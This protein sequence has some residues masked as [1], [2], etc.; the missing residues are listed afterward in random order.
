MKSS[1]A[2]GLPRIALL[3]LCACYGVTAGRANEP[4]PEPVTLE[5]ALELAFARSPELAAFQAQVEEAEG[6]LMQAGVYL[7]NPELSL[8]AGNR[9][10][11]IEPSE[12]DSSI[13]LTQ[14]I[15]VG[16]QRKR[17][18]VAAR[19]A[20]EETR[21]RFVRAR[22][23]LVTRVRIAFVEAL[24][25]RELLE[26]ENT[27]LELSRSLLDFTEKRLEAGKGT[28]IEVNLARVDF[29]QARRQA[30]LAGAGYQ[31][32]RSL[33][34]QT[35]GIDPT[36]PPE[37]RGE[38]LIPAALPSSLAELLVGARHRRADLLAA[39]QSI[40]TARARVDLAKRE[41]RPNLTFGAFYEKEEGTDTIIG[42]SLS[43]RLPVFNRNQGI[44]R[45][46]QASLSR[47]SQ[48]A[49]GT[50]LLIDREVTAT[51]ARLEAARDAAEALDEL[52]FGTLQDNLQLLQTA[53]EAGK[54]GWTEVLVFRRTFIE[55]QRDFVE[56]T[57][58][59]WEARITL[60]LAT[61]EVIQ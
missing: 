47:A 50:E 28:Q 44:I 3:L 27:N 34:A 48:E 1:R 61:G 55:G 37:P 56:T 31:A 9:S 41:V 18:K 24:R 52:V 13:E 11:T 30:A 14:E 39:R 60:D 26:I 40:E 10:S 17:R 19:S 23:I 53:F 6:G 21:D 33:L 7:H 58:E 12:T 4:A 54:I 43:L 38:L 42:G 22:R 16:G 15:E 20:L 25:A 2:V 32:T 49:L 57:A 45:R 51:F 8:G 29:G 5:Q 46:E 59:A 35:I 36:R